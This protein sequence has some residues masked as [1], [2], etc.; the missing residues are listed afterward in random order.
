MRCRA[1]A[2]AVSTL[3]TICTA[4]TIGG[5][6]AAGA[7]AAAPEAATPASAASP[8]STLSSSTAGSVSSDADRLAG[9]NRYGTSAQIAAQYPAGVPSIYVATGAS[10]P[11]AL[12]AGAAAGSGSPVVLVA[13]GTIPADV[14]AE[15]ARLKPAKIILVGGPNSVPDSVGTTLAA[16][17]GGT[18]SRLAGTNRYGTAQAVSAAVFAPGVKVAYLVS[19]VAF[20]DALTASAL[21]AL[22]GS[23]V[24][25]TDPS[26]LPQ[27]TVDELTRLAPQQIVVLGGPTSVS[28]AVVDAVKAYS[29]SVVRVAGTDR[30]ATNAAA[31]AG[32]A[33]PIGTL[34]VAAGSNFPDALSGAALAGHLGT[35]MLLVGPGGLSADQR[36]LITRLTP[37][38]VDVLGATNAVS[39][40]TLNSVLTAAG[41]QTVPVAA[42]PS[43]PPVSTGAGDYV[44][45]YS[46]AV[47]AAGTQVIRWNPCR[48]I[49]WRLN[50]PGI[51]AALTQTINTE[52][53]ALGR[54][55]GMTFRYDG[56]TSFIPQQSTVSS[57]PDD[58]VVTIAARSAS[59]FLADNPGAV[60]YGGWEAS[61]LPDGNWQITKGYVVMDQAT[62]TE[63]PEGIAAGETTGAL[64]LHELGHA[65]GLQHAAKATEIM[66]PALN[67]Q[68]PSTYSADDLM[69]LTKVGHGAGCI[70]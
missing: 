67:P 8:T 50:A 40:Q 30:Y 54:A 61:T 15:V 4:T 48:A 23:P 9:S 44:L 41:L 14:S 18:W 39:D 46:G 70:S 55:T 38:H 5:G 52:F 62:V 33:G 27:E 53:A 58:L 22:A 59:D 32:I 64:L 42:P 65:V 29:P 20:P 26:S 11:D 10:F 31:D 57:E 7:N 35:A 47:G 36:A 21:G 12:A 28:D 1:R 6:A 56:T 37:T 68:T 13:G 45:S 60:G 66:Y 3:L 2:L 25:L 69:G 17:A 24:L 51:D 43:T 63:L 16:T 34:V 49:G 19:G